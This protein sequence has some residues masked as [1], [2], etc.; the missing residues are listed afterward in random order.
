MKRVLFILLGLVMSLFAYSSPDKVPVARIRGLV[1]EDQHKF[2]VAGCAV[3]LF[4][5]QDGQEDSLYV[6]T[7]KEGVFFFDN[8]D[9][10][11]VKLKTYC[12]GYEAQEA[13]FDLVTGDNVVLFLLKE[14]VE[15]LESAMITSQ[16]A[17]M[18]KI[19]DTTIINTQAIKA[20]SGDMLRDVLG[21]VPG[22]TVTDQAVYVNGEKVERT[23]VNGLLVFGDDAMNAI[24]SLKVEEVTHI[25]SYQ[26][27]SAVDK[28]RGLIN[29]KKEQVLNII[30]KEDFLSL[31][32]YGIAAAAG[33]DESGQGRYAAAAAVAYDS[34]RL[35]FNLGLWGQNIALDNLD[36]SHP[37]SMYYVNEFPSRKPLQ[38]YSETSEINA[39][40]SKKWKNQLYG[41]KLSLS[42]SFK[43]RYYR[44]ASETLTEY[45]E[46][47][48][49]PELMQAD[50]SSFNQLGKEHLIKIKL[51]MLDTPLKSFNLD[52]DGSISDNNSNKH[53]ISTRTSGG[54]QDYSR[55]EAFRADCRD[56]K[57]FGYL[58]W[59]NNDAKKWRPEANVYL[60]IGNNTQLSWTA[61]T[62]ATSFFKRQL[63]SD[64]Y[65]KSLFAGGSFGSSVYL[66]NNKT[67][68]L[69]LNLL[70]K[71]E[72]SHLKERQIST[73][74]WDCVQ[75]VMDIANSYDHT[76]N[77]L[78]ASAL[79]AFDY[80][81]A[82]GLNVS[83]NFS[84]NS[85]KLLNTE[86]FPSDYS[87]DAIF[88]YPEYILKAKYNALSF[89]SSLKALTPS[90]EQISNRICD[91]NPLV[92]TGGNPNL[93]HSLMLDGGLSYASDIKSKKRGVVKNLIFSLSSACRFNP[94]VNKVTYFDTDTV[95]DQWDGYKALAGTMLYSYSN[96]ARPS[97]KV[98][99]A[100]DYALSLKYNRY[101]L[102]FGATANY[103][104]SSQF[105]G[106]VPVLMEDMLFAAKMSCIYMP[107][108]R[109]QIVEI[110]SLSY[111]VSND[112]AGENLSSRL[113]F[114]NDLYIK[115][116]I[117]PQKIRLECQYKITGYDY[118][119]GVGNN[120]I[121]H[122]LNAELQFRPIKGS[123]L[124]FSLQVIDMLNSATMYSTELNP[125]Y[126]TQRWEPTYGRYF[127]I[128]LQ[129]IF[130][131]PNKYSIL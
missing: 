122:I 58:N 89:T 39:F 46:T 13:E 67:H 30:T 5:M 60:T 106:D 1:C 84:L 31:A 19:K 74:E 78:V 126:M 104:Q 59:T 51:S 15:E 71:L 38:E 83:G 96:A 94:I 90:V 108:S 125:L 10:Q 14:N 69:S 12:M 91:T 100:G 6:S 9:S 75:P 77:D 35:N 130:R 66:L 111:L 24:N 92:L 43:N 119:S 124:K 121:N 48:G 115:W 95:L 40:F 86:R 50:S 101:N 7:T 65:G 53:E 127:L 103:A 93:K 49:S 120:H 87:N 23:Y 114:M 63:T 34:E 110:T 45:F 16:V 80:A 76:R 37:G 61:D 18:K 117:V 27:Q 54:I 55:N 81:S 129:Y 102:R 21:Q 116:E 28:R 98:G 113:A 73:N 32:Q 11:R 68:T 131:K 99:A 62:M 109:F 41:N 20:M 26:E 22:F 36:L 128:N 47:E 57:I 79:G 88:L 52:I 123:P 82:Q 4:Y 112:M 118:L 70:S 17:L 72:Y 105:A 42:Y 25:K 56:W 85:K 8:L 2:P 107:S 44:S 97:W 3:Q 29:S 33:A 64:A